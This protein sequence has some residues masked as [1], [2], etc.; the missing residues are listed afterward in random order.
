VVALNALT[1]VSELVS[2]VGR[3]ARPRVVRVRDFLG[4]RGV[5]SSESRASR[6][7]VEAFRSLFRLVPPSWAEP[8]A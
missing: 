8:L 4:G 3:P 7:V 1:F 5:P 2:E 6:N